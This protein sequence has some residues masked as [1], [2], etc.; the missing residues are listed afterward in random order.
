[1]IKVSVII[2]VYN[3]EKFI[4]KCLNSVVNQT[5]K[6][7]EIIVV[8]DS[9]PD[10]S[11]K[12]IDKY[13]KMYPKKVR[14]FI[15]EN[16]G[17]ST[18]RNFGLDK[19][20][21]EYI[22]FVDSDDYI[23]KDMLKKMYELAKKED[24]DV[25][26]CDIVDHFSD[27]VMYYNCTNYDSVFKVTPN[28]NN[29]IYKSKILKNRRFIPGKW[30]EDFEFIAKIFLEKDI[31]ISQISEGLYHGITG[32]TSIMN[33]NNSVKNLDIL[34]VLD[35]II[36]YAKENNVYDKDIFSYL[37]FD[38]V[39]ITTIN[40]VAQQKNNKKKYLMKE[41]YDFSVKAK[42]D[43][44]KKLNNYCK[45]NIN[46]Y[47]K[48]NFYKQVKLRRKI[49]AWLNY[50]ELYWASKIILNFKKIFKKIKWSLKKDK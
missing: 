6:E 49:I 39:L 9:S 28:V 42:N 43:V 45:E 50:H 47:K 24:S 35:E 38:H 2:P 20:T 36:R 21:G 32:H 8:N 17:V 4:D 19:A 31:K 18:A 46:D 48:Q 40:R 15:K 5:L 41:D 16:G 44:L 11:Q 10:N 22:S 13:V 37:I 34:F 30:Y 12:I 7:I 1:M 29:K 25:V 3:V 33:N 27:H 14:S 26:I 23:D